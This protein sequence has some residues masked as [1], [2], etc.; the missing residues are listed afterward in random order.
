M[1]PGEKTEALIEWDVKTGDSDFEQSGPLTTNDPKR[2]TVTLAIH[3]KIMETLRAERP[4]VHFHD[5]S[6]NEPANG[7]VAWFA[8]MPVSRWPMRTLSGRSCPFILFK[9][10]L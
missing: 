10:G 4:D 7:S 3:G 6:M 5:L 1:Q 8:D 9:S 2:Q